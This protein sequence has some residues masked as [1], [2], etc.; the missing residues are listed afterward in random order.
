MKSNRKSVFTNENCVSDLN[1][2]VKMSLEPKICEEYI[3]KALSDSSTSILSV[4]D[5]SEC[6]SEEEVA[7]NIKSFRIFNEKIKG[8]FINPR[9][10]EIEN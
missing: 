6:S 8:S 4:V 2:M 1:S 5:F 7:S 9:W 10:T 3:E